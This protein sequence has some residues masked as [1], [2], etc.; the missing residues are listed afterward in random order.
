MLL[1]ISRDN[2]IL[3]LFSAL[4]NLGLVS[5]FLHVGCVEISCRQAV[6][7][8]TFFLN[9]SHKTHTVKHSGISSQFKKN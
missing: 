7:A 9:D 4:I 2:F 5:T 8:N 1:T 3:V 6:C